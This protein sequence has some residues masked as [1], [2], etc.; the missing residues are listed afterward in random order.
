MKK[1][2]LVLL[3]VALAAFLLVGCIPVTP[4]EGEGEGE[5][6]LAK[7]VIDGAV[8]ID[9]KTYVSAGPHDVTVTFPAPVA[10]WVDG[11]IDSCYGDY[12]KAK[13]EGFVLFPD[14]TKKVWTGSA[15]FVTGSYYNANEWIYLPCCAT[16]VEI[17]TGE[18]DET[19]CIWFPVIVDGCPPYA[20]IK[21]SVANCTCAGCA[22]TFASTS[23]DPDC[24]EGELC[25]GDDCS[26]LASWAINLYDGNPFDTCCD[27]SVCEEPIGTDSGVCPIDF[28]TECLEGGKTYYAVISLVDKVG[29]EQN[30]YAK[31]DVS[32]GATTADTCSI[33]VTECF[34]VP[35]PDCVECTETGD[36]IGT[37]ETICVLGD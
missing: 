5:G 11:Y 32:G 30:Y 19:T 25:C 2:I 20:E 33:V 26:G 15:N 24:A 14:A 27:P 35:P 31:I 23:T 17:S 29:L 8:V 36:L 3:V 7:V 37:C 28:T 6:E 34:E 16:Y 22:I 9:G 13:D 10:N 18:C 12:S 1:L 4:G 21:V